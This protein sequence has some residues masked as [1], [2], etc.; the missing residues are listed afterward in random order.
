MPRTVM[1][2]RSEL[3]WTSLV[4]STSMAP[5]GST[6]ETRAVSVVEITTSRLVVPWPA[7]CVSPL[8]PA[9]LASG[10]AALVMPAS[11]LTEFLVLEVRCR[12]GGA[13][14]DGGG[15]LHHQRR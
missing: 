7:S 5:L 15:A 13:V 3:I 10:P 14:G 4:A 8:T 9:R 1:V 2:W 12:L 11:A 6:P